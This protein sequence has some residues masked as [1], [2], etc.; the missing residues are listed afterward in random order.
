MELHYI[1]KSN[2]E[3]SAKT[4]FS[5]RYMTMLMRLYKKTGIE[6]V[7]LNQADESPAEYI[8]GGKH[9]DRKDD[10]GAARKTT[11]EKHQLQ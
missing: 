4:G 1:G 5:E 8:R 7:H 11:G 9:T 2:A 6:R 3:I 10:T